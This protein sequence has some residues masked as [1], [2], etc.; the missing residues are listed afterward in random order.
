M[1]YIK[2]R[3]D[4]YSFNNYGWHKGFYNEEDIMKSLYQIRYTDYFEESE[5]D[6]FPYDSA[7]QLLCGSCNH[8]AVALNKLLNYNVYIIEG[9]NKRNF[10]FS[11]RRHPITVIII[12]NI[13]FSVYVSHCC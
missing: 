7:Y 3:K 5:D 1:L 10:F 6:E 4:L 13:F 11:R 2:D 9:N 8:F 12:Y